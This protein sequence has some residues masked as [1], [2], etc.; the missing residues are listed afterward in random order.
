MNYVFSI[1]NLR[2]SFDETVNQFFFDNVH[3]SFKKNTMNFIRGKNGAGKSTLFRILMGKIERGELIEGTITLKD[4][5][6]DLSNPEQR[7]KLSAHIRLAP[8][9]FDEMLADQFTFTQNMALASLPKYPGL[10]TF[11]ETVDIPS[12]VDRF[13]INYHVPV[14]MLSGGQRQILAILMA[15]Q[16]PTSVL[17]LDEPTAA[18]D[19]KNA[20]MVIAFLQALLSANKELTVLIICH[21]KELVEEYAQD[22]YHQIEVNEDKTRTIELKPFTQGSKL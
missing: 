5:S 2:F 15:I 3:G 22:H 6:F 18:L 4:H 13:G 19:D 21:D 1:K 9:K 8:Q 11:V 20:G 10:E 14:G 17:L 16:K 7:S 12:I